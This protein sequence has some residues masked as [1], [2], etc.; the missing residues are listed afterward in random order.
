MSTSTSEQSESES[1][2]SDSVLAL[3]KR[4]YHVPV[5]SLILAFML[6]IRLKPLDKFTRG[7]EIFFAGN[8]AWYHY[9]QVSW[10]VRNWPW[11]MPYDVYSEFPTGVRADQ[12][13]TLFDQLV[14]TAAL[15]VGLGSPDQQTIGMTLL[16][17]PAVFGMLV[18]IPTYFIG[19][20]LAGRAGGLTAALVLALLPGVFL[21]RSTAGFS[22]HHVAEVLFQ[23]LAVLGVMVALR[24][25]EREKPIYELVVDRDF[26]GLREPTKWAA[27]AGL[28]VGLYMWVWPP[29]VVIVGLLGVFYTI[30]LIFEYVAGRS[31]EHVAYSGVV[32]GAVAGLV[33]LVQIDQLSLGVTSISPLQV[34]L[35]FGLAA[36]CAFLAGLARKWNEYDA[37]DLLKGSGALFAVLLVGILFAPVVGYPFLDLPFALILVFGGLVAALVYAREGLRDRGAS[38]ALAVTSLLT[39]GLLLLK[40]VSPRAFG[41]IVRNIERTIALSQSDTTLTIGEAQAVVGAGEPFF[42]TATQFFGAQY[43][44]TYVVAAAALVWMVGYLYFKND[45]RVEYLFVVVWSVFILLMALT[46]IR[47]NYYLAVTVAVLNGWFV[48]RIVRFIGLA[49]ISTDDIDVEPYQVMSVIA[50][51]MLIVMPLTPVLAMTSTTVDRQAEGMSPGGVLN[52][53]SSTEWLQEN[54]PEPGKYGGANNELPYYGR[55]DNQEDF[56][57]P[58]GAYGVISWWDYGHWITVK[59]ERVPV[60]NPFQHNA[61]FASQYLLAENETRGELLLEAL[62]TIDQRE[63]PIDQL[64]NDELQQFVDQQNE[65]Q[66]GED[67]RYVMIDYQMASSKFGA[68]AT[69]TGPGPQAYFGQEQKQI[70]NQS[71]VLPST[72]DKYD[73]TMLSKLYYGDAEGLEHYRLVHEAP[74]QVAIASV[75]VQRQGQIQATNFV[76]RPMSVQQYFQYQISNQTHVYDL[77]VES[78]VKTYERVPGATITGQVDVSEPTNVTATVPLNSSTLG[79]SFN[80]TQTVQTD[81]SGNFEITVPYATDDSVSVE[82]GGTNSAV[83]ATGEYTITVEGSNQT[84]TAAV[85]ESAIM[86]EDGEPITVEFTAGDDSQNSTE[87]PDGS[88]T[89][90][91]SDTTNSS[92]SS[93]TTATTTTSSTSDST[94]TATTT[95]ESASMTELYARAG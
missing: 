54:T 30:A 12:F 11:T 72:T 15:V 92:D 83:T 6:W 65:Q 59:G 66:A 55:Y 42:S 74:Q 90:D 86:T 37:A 82:Q 63:K 85:S 67:T 91:G 61:K 68:I 89:S 17:A 28:A 5:L 16:V 81:A 34:G 39:A 51:L 88:N 32:I 47:F 49:N 33:T 79:R 1:V 60:A 93:N 56:A 69:W 52:W 80:Y 87:S 7:G 57:Y 35:A 62:P 29:A 27:L 45:Y 58:E 84:A 46:Q 23:A 40:L 50:V 77:S 70:N 8:D 64:S 26:D 41:V 14:A 10:T 20:R 18:A 75:A 73:Q 24:S 95:S 3:F 71:V 44:M 21:R 4:W 48:G 19:K 13:G 38:Y 2:S 9:R 22:D 25:A 94:T 53:N 76:N 36:G 78:T 31:P 43:G